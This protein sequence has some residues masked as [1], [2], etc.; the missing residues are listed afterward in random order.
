MS[1][2]LALADGTATGGGVDYGAGLE[3]STDG[4]TNWNPATTATIAA[5][6][7]SVLVRTPINNDALNEAAETFTLTATRTAGTTTNASV[8]GTA[9]INDNDAAPSLTINDVTVNEGAG[10]ATF[11]VTLSAASGL[12]ISV[13]YATSNGTALAGS[14]YTS[15]SGTLN[16]AAG[17]TSQTITV[18]ILNDAVFENSETFNVL[19]SSAGQ[20]DDRGRFRPRHDPR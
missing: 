3:V 4:G 20:C 7:T 1:F 17:V 12:P 11:T 14:D 18:P 2:S 8:V 19:L 9:T 5:G 15:G 10:T 16:F 6:A 13:N